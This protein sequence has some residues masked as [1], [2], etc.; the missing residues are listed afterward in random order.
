VPTLLQLQAEPWWDREIITPELDWL[1]DELCRRTGAPPWSIGT[2]G[3][4]NHLNGGHRSQEW[5][6]QSDWCTNIHYTVQT[7]LSGEQPRHIAALDRTPLAWGTPANRAQMVVE[8]QRLLDAARAGR[9]PGI[10]QIQGTLD[11]KT[12]YGQNFPSLITTVPSDS[13]LDHWHLTFDRRY[14]RD[15]ALM[16]RIADVVTGTRKEIEML[17][18]RVAGSPRV[19]LGDGQTCRGLDSYGLDGVQEAYKAL[20]DVAGVQQL[21]DFTSKAALEAALGK[22]VSDDGG[23]GGGTGGGG[24]DEITA[25]RIV[26]EELDKTHLPAVPGTLQG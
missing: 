20:K 7:G 22:E 2:K 25:R 3:D 6:V 13:H 23:N 26:R 18:A 12:T 15:A 17:M 16:L 5:I 8:T 24:I 9:L 10:T 14:L 11:G 21:P 1:G 4:E 19:Y